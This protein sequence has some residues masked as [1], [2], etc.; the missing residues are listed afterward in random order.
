MTV[1]EFLESASS[2]VPG[3]VDGNLVTTIQGQVGPQGAAGV[4]GDAGPAGATG[5]IIIGTTASPAANSFFYNTL[6][7]RLYLSVPNEFGDLA[8]VRIN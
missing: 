1:Q 7:S 3:A 8:F 4:Q 6:E 2:R 5:S